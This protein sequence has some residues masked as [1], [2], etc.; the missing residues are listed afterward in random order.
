[1]EWA[2]QRSIE[3]TRLE[4]IADFDEEFAD[5]LIAA[6]SKEPE[7]QLFQFEMIL[8]SR[9]NPKVRSLVE[10]LYAGYIGTVEDALTRRGLD[11]GGQTSLAI[12]A[13][14]DGLMFQLVTISD[15]VTI[16]AAVI[17]VGRL[18]SV[19]Q[20]STDTSGGVFDSTAATS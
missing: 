17:R 9:R 4:R 13:A 10:R 6:V 1:M 14:L 19:L 2:F 18:V 5:S 8:E 11:T 3:A 16:R 12:F 20:T 7:L 15:P